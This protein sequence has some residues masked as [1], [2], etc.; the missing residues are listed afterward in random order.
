MALTKRADPRRM[1]VLR[2]SFYPS[3]LLSLIGAGQAI[4][5]C[6]GQLHSP[7]P[8]LRGSRY[9]PRLSPPLA[10]SVRW[11]S[12]AIIPLF[13]RIYKARKRKNEPPA[14]FKPCLGAFY[15]SFSDFLCRKKLCIFINIPSKLT[16]PDALRLANRHFKHFRSAYVQ[17]PKPLI[18]RA[19]PGFG[20][21]RRSRLL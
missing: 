1:A 4:C 8:T 17:S 19:F 5:G 12:A 9:I 2:G 15:S 11:G 20:R 7:Q 10:T 21:F 6:S 13:D 18:F 3:G 16:I 14:R